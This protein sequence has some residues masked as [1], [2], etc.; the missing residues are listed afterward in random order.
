MLW[1]T[2]VSICEYFLLL[3]SLRNF[4]LLYWQTYAR[5]VPKR[6]DSISTPPT[7]ILLFT[8]TT[9]VHHPPLSLSPAMILRLFYGLNSLH[10]VDSSTPS[11]TRWI[12]YNLRGLLHCTHLSTLPMTSNSNLLH[13]GLYLRRRPARNRP[14]RIRLCGER[15]SVRKGRSSLSGTNLKVIVHGKPSSGSPGYVC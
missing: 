8:R 3:F 4:L 1:P 11:S 6:C 14:T 13:L 15:L 2:T 10:A 7:L 9:K 5:D 12:Y